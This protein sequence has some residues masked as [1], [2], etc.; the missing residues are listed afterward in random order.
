[1][2]VESNPGTSAEAS[3]QTEAFRALRSIGYA[4]D[5]CPRRMAEK[6]SNESPPS[7]WTTA[8]VLTW[9]R[10]KCTASAVLS[11]L[12]LSELDGSA[13]LAIQQDDLIHTE[14]FE[15]S[16]VDIQQVSLKGLGIDVTWNS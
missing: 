6:M 9:S 16:G 3:V 15:L 4:E 12:Q 8:E 1:V 11:F 10:T 5:I 13:L 2:F 7:Q 14:E